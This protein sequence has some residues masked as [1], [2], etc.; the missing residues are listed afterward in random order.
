MNQETMKA[1]NTQLP[2]FPAFPIKSDFSFLFFIDVCSVYFV[3]NNFPN[4]SFSSSRST[5]KRPT[6]NDAVAAGEGA[7]QTLTTR[8]DS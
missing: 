3:V 6:F 2:L 1:G 7:L 5:I 4:Q 8:S